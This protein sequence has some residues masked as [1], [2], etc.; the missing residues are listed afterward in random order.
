METETRP[1]FELR[2]V[3]WD[4]GIGYTPITKELIGVGCIWADAKRC[5]CDEP[6]IRKAKA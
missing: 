5:L 2:G 4:S 3:P 6:R 1:C